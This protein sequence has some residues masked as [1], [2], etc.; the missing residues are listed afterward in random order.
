M[1]RT[2]FSTY[3]A[4]ELDPEQLMALINHIDP[5]TV[6]PGADLPTPVREWIRGDIVCSSCGATGA[7]I[8]R[9]S[10]SRARASVVRQGHFRFV[11]ATGDD[12]HH[13]FCEFRGDASDQHNESLVEL[14]NA[15]TTETRWIRALVCK[16]IENGIFNQAAIRGMRQWFFDLKTQS[17]MRMSV[18]PE[19]VDWIARL[20]RHPSHY[21][22][23]FHPVH[24]EMPGY[25]WDLAATY[26]FTEDNLPLFELIRGAPHEANTRQKAKALA[27]R[28]QGLEVF[29]PAVLRPYYDVT[30]S[31]AMFIARNSDSGGGK[32][33]PE[34]YRFT[35]VPLALLALCAL[36]LFI[37]NWDL[38]TAIATSARLFAA[39]RATDDTL[40]NV[41]GLN[42]FHDYAPWKLLAIASTVAA[43]SPNGFE[44][45]A[46]LRSIEA[47][48]RET[49]RQWKAGGS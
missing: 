8:V 15:R 23:P 24:A 35:G 44:Y 34:E 13:R 47:R 1:P 32:S 43:Q 7:Q 36:L 6:D 10:H 3:Y 12:A 19:A 28:Y 45:E 40:G 27:L 37:S 33:R 20:Q 5:G 48:L 17:R 46:Q 39:P 21:R 14:G 41:I 25:R 22:W 4:R 42:P 49:H 31:L 26:Q 29:D 16:G 18:P 38:N 11:S 9:P 2:A 30:L